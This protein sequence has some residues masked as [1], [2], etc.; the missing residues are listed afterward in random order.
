MA[1]RQGREKGNGQLPRAARHPAL[2]PQFAGRHGARRLRRDRAVGHRLQLD[3]LRSVLD[4]TFHAQGLAENL[5]AGK[6]TYWTG[7]TSLLQNSALSGASTRYLFDAVYRPQKGLPDR[8]PCGHVD[9]QLHILEAEHVHGHLLDDP[10]DGLHA[11]RAVRR[12]RDLLP[13]VFRRG[14]A[15]PARRLLQHRTLGPPPSGPSRWACSPAPGAR[16]RRWK[17][18]LL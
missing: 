1:A 14:C 16:A 6:K 18:P 2:A 11:D 7:I 15:A 12:L 5:I 10:A 4:K 3:L 8:V 13:R 17:R 9:D